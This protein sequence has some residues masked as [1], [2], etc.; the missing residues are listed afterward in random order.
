M[1]N[2]IGKHPRLVLHTCVEYFPSLRSHTNIDMCKL[3]VL[4]GMLTYT[5]YLMSLSA[6][7]AS[8]F[9]FQHTYTHTHKQPPPG[10]RTEKKI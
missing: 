4:T 10:V 1:Y 3:R 9:F 7:I 2:M 8:R 6:I 5:A